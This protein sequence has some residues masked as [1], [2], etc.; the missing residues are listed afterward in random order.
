MLELTASLL[1]GR[2]FLSTAPPKDPIYNWWI[3]LDKK[4]P[5]SGATDRSRA[6]DR[7]YCPLRYFPMLEGVP[8]MNFDPKNQNSK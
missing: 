4:I 8:A 2:S 6:T 7:P 5:G 3:T 1:A